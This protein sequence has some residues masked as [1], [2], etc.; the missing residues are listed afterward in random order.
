MNKKAQEGPRL[1]VGV[2][3]AI[4]FLTLLYIILLP[5]SEKCKI[6]PDLPFCNVT[7]ITTATSAAEEK[8]TLLSE[9]P[10]LLEPLEQAEEYKFGS[11]NLFSKEETEIPIKLI[12]EPII[13]KSWFYYKDLVQHFNTP[14]KAK[15]VIL[16]VNIVEAPTAEI[17]RL[18]VWLNGE[19]IA[20][21]HGKGLQSIELPT[22]LIKED[23]EILFHSSTPLSPFSK[24]HFKLSAL[25]VKQIYELTQ[26]SI[27][28]DFTIQNLQLLRSATL[29]FEADCY[30][31]DKLKIKLNGVTIANERVCAS[32]SSDVTSLLN[33]SN[34]LVFSSDG[35]YFLRDVKIETNFR[36]PE[37]KTYFFALGD[38]QYNALQKGKRLAMLKILFT[39]KNSKE[40][41]VY[42]NGNP[43][44]IK[45][46]TE[47]EYS[48]AVSKLLLQGQNSVRLV[49]SEKAITIANLD[50]WVE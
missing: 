12:S 19:K 27:R 20:T 28:K 42:I 3:L 35:N 29:T 36:Q 46:W 23:N 13:E 33:S 15:R 8:T 24:N 50:L 10:G 1:V 21:L 45:G 44:Y 18:G 37:Y 5:R 40:L 49:P 48:T 4:A 9:Q 2:V 41:T 6:L 11:I 17:A 47:L 25:I 7:N 38:E 34:E 14:G 30:S 39:D 16:F 32:Y 43:I 31:N 26:S 22:Q